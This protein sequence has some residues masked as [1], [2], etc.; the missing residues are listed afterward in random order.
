MKIGIAISGGGFRAT[1][2]SLGVFSYL[3]HL[4]FEGKPLLQHVEA[5]STVSGG[6]ITGITYA[7]SAKNN[8]CFTN[9]FTNMYEFI[10]KHDL[11][12]S[13]ISNFVNTSTKKS[14]IEGFAKS[15]QEE[16]FPLFVSCNCESKS[17]TEC[18]CEEHFTFSS[19]IPENK[20]NNGS[21][22]YDSHIKYNCINATDFNTGTPFRFIAKSPEVKT[23]FVFGNNFHRIKNNG[24]DVPLRLA[25]AASSCFPGGFEPIMFDLTG[26]DDNIICELSN[27]FDALYESNKE[28]YPN[29]KLA[30]EKYIRRYA[31]ISLMD[32]GI[33]DNQ[34]IESIIR[35]DNAL[36]QEE[37][38][39]IDA[40]ILE[41]V[42]KEIKEQNAT[43]DESQSEIKKQFEGLKKEK[44]KEVEGLDM[45]MVVDVSSPSFTRYEEEDE[46]NISLIGDIKMIY[47]LNM[48]MFLNLLFFI[49]LM[50]SMFNNNMYAILFFTFFTTLFTLVSF[51]L[52]VGKRIIKKE[53]NKNDVSFGDVQKMNILTPNTVVQLAKNRFSSV[54]LLVGSVFMKH[55]RRQN[56][57]NL[58]GIQELRRKSIHNAIYQLKKPTD[59]DKKVSMKFLE[60]PKNLNQPTR[61]IEQICTNAF[62]MNTSLWVSKEDN[63][64]KLIQQVIIAAQI[65]TCANLLVHYN[66]KW[67][68]KKKND[69]LTVEE[70]LANTI[71]NDWNRFVNDPYWLVKDKYNLKRI[72]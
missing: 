56:I 33:V 48:S 24:N 55:L 11:V 20:S 8:I 41:L 30:K 28:K 70:K 61:L 22:K 69:D 46:V 62:K 31:N 44:Y 25:L 19:I 21:D 36:K 52:I 16:L 49:G 38:H 43:T 67:N 12:S 59:I 47:L 5:L 39:T 53:S 66:G 60:I 2:Y 51:L 4:E 18:K 29:K 65:T 45:I 54:G 13:S 3:N 1:T 57:A 42:D 10:T 32:G 14:L 17:E 26:I 27:D 58:F 34:G 6:S 15:Y 40:E 68:F 9:Y 23:N 7:L 63:G 71:Y 35:Y 37:K 72:D 50:I 64:K